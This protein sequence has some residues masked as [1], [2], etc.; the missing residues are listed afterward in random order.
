LRALLGAAI[1]LRAFK[2]IMLFRYGDMFGTGILAVYNALRGVFTMLFIM[3]ACFLAFTTAYYVMIKNAADGSDLLVSVYRGLMLGDEDSLERIGGVWGGEI[4]NTLMVFGT[5]VFTVYLLNIMIAVL[6][7]EYYKADRRAPLLLWRERAFKSAQALL[8]PVCPWS[9]DAVFDSVCS[10]PTASLTSP[11]RRTARNLSGNGTSTDSKETLEARSAASMKRFADVLVVSLL[12]GAVAGFWLPVHAV[13][14]AVSLG[15]ALVV[16]HS[17]L[18]RGRFVGT[19]RKGKKFNLWV[20][21]RSDYSHLNF[22]SEEVEKEHIDQ[23]KAKV[24]RMEDLLH[25][26]HKRIVSMSQPQAGGGR[27]P[28]SRA[29]PVDVS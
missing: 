13:W 26:M 19:K 17:R 8:G 15:F 24:D 21:H 25:D 6:T 1:I 16:I 3:A 27:S 20:C 5:G 2:L 11:S 9:I 23:L 7:A 28:A 14:S 12:A 4:G 10:V 18:M 22:V 29:G